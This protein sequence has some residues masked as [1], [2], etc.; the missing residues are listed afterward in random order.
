MRSAGVRFMERLTDRV[1]QLRWLVLVA[2]L[3]ITGALASQVPKLQFDVSIENLLDPNDPDVLMVRDV[4]DRLGPSV[5]TI[6]AY[7]DEALFTPEGLARL[8]ALTDRIA[9]I[10]N[11][12]RVQSLTNASIVSGDG[13]GIWTRPLIETL[14][15]TQEEAEAIKARAVTN[16]VTRD[17]LVN[18]DGT[19]A[20]LVVNNV[21]VHGKDDDMAPKIIEDIRV[22]AAE[23]LDGFEYHLT[24]LAV[25]YR[26]MLDYIR[27]DLFLLGAAPTLLIALVLF[28]LYRNI[29]GVILPLVIVGMTLAQILGIMSLLGV[30]L[31]V[32]SVLLPP[33]ILVIG[34][35]DAV[36]IVTQVSEANRQNPNANRQAVL[37]DA[38]GHVGLACTLTSL[39]T[40]AGFASLGVSSIR[41]VRE[42]G[43]YAAVAIGLALVLSLTL[44]PA[45][46]YWWKP[47]VGVGAKAEA[48]ALTRVLRRIAD[49]DARH[50]G[51][52]LVASLVITA[53]AVAGIPQI[54]VEAGFRDQFRPNSPIVKSIDFVEEELTGPELLAVYIRSEESLLRPKVLAG[55]NE[56]AEAMRSHESVRRADSVAD[57]VGEAMALVTP[58]KTLPDNVEQAEQLMLMLEMGDDDQIS[59]LIN[60]DRT[61]ARIAGRVNTIP[62][63]EAAK[64][65]DSVQETVAGLDLPDV[66]FRPIG[67]VYMFQRLV[68][69]LIDSQIKSFGLAF[70]II[71]VMMG[72]VLR[73]IRLAILSMVPNLLPIVV[74][75][76]VMGWTDLPLN[77]GTIMTASI[78]IG[79]A[80]D[81]TIHF[82]VR[83]RAEMAGGPA[84]ANL[85][86]LE[87]V[88]RAVVTTSA[89]LT[90]GFLV[91]TLASFNAPIYFGL[92]STVTIMTALLADLFV[93]PV[94]LMIFQR[95]LGSRTSA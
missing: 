50:K 18:A 94:L 82:L 58:G 42:F 3:A 51:P 29:Q 72:L 60:G 6:L 44:T 39:T 32:S 74:M 73:S 23:D 70:V 87:A 76:G 19:V 33:L 5:P 21:Y 4:M 78:A 48:D 40:M 84:Q 9:D 59:M 77:E 95:R 53:M 91:T 90:A 66:S 67:P 15:E 56:I 64:I 88:G 35:A 1:I 71:F 11:V 20:A 69:A 68:H 37:R 25:F 63:T 61:A 8:G 54:R 14:P 81:D 16:R 22:I 89:V 26:Q 31:G 49:I 7:R 57:V 30:K 27:R 92:L 46:L 83:Y 12:L 52:V 65:V 85:R 62:T 28:M 55:M 86:T 75:L 13:D 80:V 34:C 43:I 17:N 2:S 41:T 79:I 45:L 93:L 38:M 36:H 47:K 24:G 10:E